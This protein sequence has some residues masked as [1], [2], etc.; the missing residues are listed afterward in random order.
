M[1]DQFC[2]ECGEKLSACTTCG[3]IVLASAQ[4]CPH[5]GAAL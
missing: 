3:R 1:D 5:C 4:R 2:R